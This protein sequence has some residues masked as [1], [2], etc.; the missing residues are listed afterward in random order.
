MQLNEP[1]TRFAPAQRASQEEILRQAEDFSKMSLLC[2]LLDGV[3]D[4][5]LVL[6]KQRQI[7]FS[8]Y[9]GMKN[10][11]LHERTQLCGIRPGEVIDCIHA[12]ETEGGCGTTE[13]CRECGAVNAILTSQR[14][15]KVSLECRIVQSGTSEA[16]DLRVTAVP[17]KIYEQEY[18]LF[19]VEDISDEKRR[20]ALERIFFHDILNTAGC[21]L[22]YAKILKEADKD[23]AAG[24]QNDVYQL[25]EKIVDEIKSQ[26]ELLAAENN[27]LIVRPAR[28]NSRSILTDVLSTYELDENAMGKTIHIDERTEEIEFV[29]DMNLLR[30]VL[31]NL[32]KN[33][34][35]A[36]S[37]GDTVTI[38]CSR[39]DEMAQF[40]VHNPGYMPK[41]VQLNIFQRSFSTKGTGRGLGTYSILLLTERYLKGNVSFTSDPSAGTCFYA[42][43]PL[44]LEV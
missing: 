44:S 33:A 14:G 42:R 2:D 25:A 34:L 37:T 6:N 9:S 43:F 28:L 5:V 16:M 12:T 30:R 26:R 19:T 7:I 11:G 3:P 18:T 22:G 17:F 13:F 4:I 8:N 40:F 1:A 35:E 23:R 15:E 29:S 36:C 27:E 32:V 10:T 38:G 24:L 20:M 41:D 39:F 31:G 21:I